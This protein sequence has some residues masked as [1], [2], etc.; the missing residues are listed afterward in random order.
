MGRKSATSVEKTAE[1]P[2]KAEKKT[3]RTPSAYLFF[4]KE[5][6]VTIKEKNPELT[7]GEVSKA[8]GEAWKGLS[9]EEKMPFIEQAK[10]AKV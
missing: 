4:A 5:T 7:F 2:S 8:V 6:R 10:A 3:K 9:E 1:K